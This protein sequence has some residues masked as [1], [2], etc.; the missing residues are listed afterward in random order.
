MD[1]VL[2]LHSDG[3]LFIAPALMTFSRA[4][5]CVA[6]KTKADAEKDEKRRL[7]AVEQQPVLISAQ[8]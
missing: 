6:L 5:A 1:Q 7:D 2:L 4:L 8:G 3:M